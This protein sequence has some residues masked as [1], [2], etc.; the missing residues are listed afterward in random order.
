MTANDSKS[1]HGYFNE[2]VDQYN[3]TYYRSIGIKPVDLIIMLW[4]KK[5]GRFLKILNLK[6]VIES[7][8]LSKSRN[9][10]SKSY[11]KNWLRDIFITDSV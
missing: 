5:L 9:I 11:T 1:Y 3:N 6:L 8:L 10:F 2:L 7:E 4:L